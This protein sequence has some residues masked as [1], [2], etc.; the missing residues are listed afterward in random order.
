MSVCDRNG[1][2]IF[3]SWKNKCSNLCLTH[4]KLD[5]IKKCMS[6]ELKSRKILHCSQVYK[7]V[8]FMDHLSTDIL[9]PWLSVLRVGLHLLSDVLFLRSITQSQSWAK[10][11]SP[12]DPWSDR[13]F[14]DVRPSPR[15]TLYKEV[16]L[17]LPSATSGSAVRRLLMIVPHIVFFIETW[18]GI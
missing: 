6:I 9:T 2:I 7:M 12:P 1:E 5:I 17:I 13:H 18:T 11:K 10:T 8:S 16:I 15:Q 4:T 3:M 14:T